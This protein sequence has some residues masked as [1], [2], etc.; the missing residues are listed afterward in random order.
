[1][2]FVLEALNPMPDAALLEAGAELH[3]GL[4]SLSQDSEVELRL[5]TA[6]GSTLL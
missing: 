6:G 2:W 1:M 5:M 3:R 4:K